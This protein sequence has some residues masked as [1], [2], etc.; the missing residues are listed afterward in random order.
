MI[1]LQGPM[2]FPLLPIQQGG[3]DSGSRRRP[4]ASIVGADEFL[5]ASD[6]GPHSMGV[7][8]TGNGDPVRGTLEWGSYP[9]SMCK[10]VK[11]YRYPC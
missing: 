1:D 6:M 9:E 5:I 7:F 10:S 3:D 8:L 11:R 4:L 2:A